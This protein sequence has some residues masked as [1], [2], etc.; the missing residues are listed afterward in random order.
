MPGEKNA[1]VRRQTIARVAQVSTPLCS[2]ANFSAAGARIYMHAAQY[3][4][5]CD[6]PRTMPICIRDFRIFFLVARLDKRGALAGRISS[7][8]SR[9]LIFLGRWFSGSA[10]GSLDLCERLDL[11]LFSDM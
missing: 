4:D 1:Q 11:S 9:L 10:S 3:S 5:H 8:R 6:V 2:P 7:A